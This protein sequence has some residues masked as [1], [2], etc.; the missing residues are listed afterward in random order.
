MALFSFFKSPGTRQFGYQPRFWNKEREELE[1]RLQ[2]A[3][4]SEGD[5]SD[6]Q[7]MKSRISKNFRSRAGITDKSSRSSQVKAS[8]YRLLLT[9]V[10]LIVLSYFVLTV[11]L[12]KIIAF[13]ESGQ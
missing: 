11:M 3:N 10:I 4:R 9:V 12:P 13:V 5:I 6:T 1:A 8:N 2:E 7:I